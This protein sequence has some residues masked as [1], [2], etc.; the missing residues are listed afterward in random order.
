[1]IDDNGPAA[2]SV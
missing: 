2:K 1:M